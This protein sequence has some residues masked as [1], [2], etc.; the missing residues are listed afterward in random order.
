M[1]VYWE[2]KYP[3]Y[4]C[5]G[6]FGVP[7]V[8]TDPAKL[9]ELYDMTHEARGQGGSFGFPLISVVGDS[10]CKYLDGRP[11]LKARDLD[12]VRVHIMAMKAIFRQGLKGHQG[13]LSK[14]LHQ[15]LGAFRAKVTDQEA[16]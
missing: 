1:Q 13:G 2:N 9:K 12:V 3:G 5:A 14:E 6:N 16:G 10:L 7:A 4:E 8:T 15:L 11:R